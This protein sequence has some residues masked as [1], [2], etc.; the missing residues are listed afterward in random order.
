MK[1]YLYGAA[2]LAAIGALGWSHVSAYRAGRAA[3]QA[4]FIQQINRE[5]SNAGN[6]AE[7][8]RAEFRRCTGA[9]G[10]YDFETGACDK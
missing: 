4:A 3:E 1:G 8:W 10:M 5:N 6:T 9:G 2:A 7:D